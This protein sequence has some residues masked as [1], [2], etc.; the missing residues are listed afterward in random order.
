MKK[1]VVED[2]LL[3]E[4]MS[5]VSESVIEEMVEHTKKAMSDHPHI[6]RIV[7]DLLGIHSLDFSCLRTLSIFA[8][9]MKKSEVKFYLLHSQL[10]VVK[11]I[12]SEGLQ[13]L[14]HCIHDLK[15][16]RKP[17]PVKKTV[18]VNFL[19]PFIEATLNTLKIQCAYECVSARPFMKDANF[20]A[21]IDI[22][23]VISILS[24]EF[25]GSISICFPENIFLKLMSN[26]LGEECRAITTETEDGAG[27]LVNII[28]GQA[29]MTLNKLGYTLQKAIPTIVRGGE[30]RVRHITPYSTIIL[31]FNSELGDFYIEI[32]I[33]S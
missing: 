31:P 32:A 17:V 28:F 11:Y 16:I 24:D 14:I 8:A 5:D 27:E 23:G 9:S 21:A 13:N 7:L 4:T 2:I 1:N 20:K 3:F 18:D 12:A 6:K 30:L 26:M 33:E 10:H 22:A 29:K 19:N 25:K 15:E